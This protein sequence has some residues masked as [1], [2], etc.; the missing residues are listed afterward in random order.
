MPPSRLLVAAARRSSRTRLG[1]AEH[2]R[3]LVDDS[4]VTERSLA[5]ATGLAQASVCRILEGTQRPSLETYQRLAVALG[6][7]LSVRLYPTTGPALR[8]RHQARMLEALLAMVHPRWQPYTEVA[9]QRPSRGWIDTALHDA[10]AGRILATELQSELRRLEQLIR[11]HAAKA[12][13]LPS[14]DGWQHLSG[15]EPAIGRLLVVR[16]TRTT[17]AVA[18]EFARQL[19]VAYPAH[20]DD[21]L[22]SLTTPLT[23]WPGN[24][25][26]WSEI[27]GGRTRLLSGR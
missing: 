17:Q 19:R 6:A 8:D 14:W 15:G 22:A 12:D 1:L 24:A 7:D 11:W 5:E 3:R 13:S 20:P 2:L 4:G 9:V 26:V 16:R 27:A 18:V 21:A 25:M 10:G 23:P